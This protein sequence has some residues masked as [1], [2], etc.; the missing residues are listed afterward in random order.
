MAKNVI[1]AQSGGPTPVINS[2]LRGI[3]DTCKQFPRAFGTLYAGWHGIEG[4]LK[5]ELL[6]LS[7][8]DAEEV[9]LLRYTPAAGSIGTCR[10]KLKQGQ[11]ED[12]QRVIDVFK[13]H[14]IG[15]FFY[16]GGNDS[17]DTANKVSQRAREKGLDLV[18]VGVPKT[19]DND[20]GDS[21]F[22]LIDHTPGYGSVA[23]YWMHAVTNANEENAG[24]CPADPVLVLQA[25]G[26]KIGYIPAASRLADPKR[27]W[28]LQIY[29]A[30]SG[31]TARE[32]CDHVNDQLKRDGRCI[33]VVSEGFEVGDVGATKDSFGHTQYSASKTTVAQQVVTM[34]NANGL[35]VGGAARGQVPGTDQRDAAIYASIVDLDEAYNVGQ[36][37][38]LIAQSGETGYMAT[39]LRRPGPIYNVDYDKVPL[40]KVANSERNFP[41]AWLTPDKLDVTDAFLDYARPLVGEDWPSV[42]TVGGRQRFTRFNPVFAEKKLAVY[43]TQADRK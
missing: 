33:V 12:F 16:I 27:E 5:E 21:E 25:M 23:R 29:M 34:L 18:A 22:K 43:V 26:R 15:Y 13:A 3:I 35:P 9:A 1:I 7:A 2:S 41:K 19:I 38:A 37:A 14:G 31:V 40:D 24:S 20:V 30:E 32:M 11:D 8:Q 10:Y 36:Q 4:V 28:P 17:M 6:D 39:I 42:P